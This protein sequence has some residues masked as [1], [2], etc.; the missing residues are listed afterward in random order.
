MIVTELYFSRSFPNVFKNNF[1]F[2]FFSTF[3]KTKI[4]ERL[5]ND[6][7]LSFV[8]SDGEFCNSALITKNFDEFCLI[9]KFFA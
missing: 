2:V 6:L 9:F 3:N 4:D 7:A 1:L 8:D 5:K